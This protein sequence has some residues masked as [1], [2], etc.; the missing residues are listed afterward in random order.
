MR[1]GRIH[2]GGR[3]A[4]LGLQFEPSLLDSLVGAFAPRVDWR[5]RLA[6]KLTAVVLLFGLISLGATVLRINLPFTP[7]PITLQTF[8]VILAGGA[9]GLR[10]G[11]ATVALYYLI[12]LAG[13][14][15]FAN[16]S[17]GWAAISGASGGYLVGFFVAASLAGL[18][19]QLGANRWNS[20]WAMLAGSV[21]VYVI[22]LPWLSFF[23]APGWPC[24]AEAMSIDSI[25]SPVLWC[26]L[27]PFVIGDLLKTLAAAL[28]LVS[29]WKVA[30]KKRASAKRAES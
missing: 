26:G 4:R 7:V 20:I 21:V 28:I 14:P 2:T 19:S 1:F 18:M 24:S 3:L 11:L 22:G 12:G 29:L 10:W 25:N 23:V 5:G 9:L 16:G 15:I 6:I 8:G 17:S 13:A 27:Y 30:D